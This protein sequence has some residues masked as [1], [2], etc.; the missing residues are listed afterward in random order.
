M[1]ICYEWSYWWRNRWKVLWKI[2]AKTKETE[3]RIEKLIQ[4]KGN[5]LYVKWKGYDNAFK[6]WIDKKYILKNDS[7]FP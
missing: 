1:D 7:V 5:M 6:S 4:K 3:F 2:I